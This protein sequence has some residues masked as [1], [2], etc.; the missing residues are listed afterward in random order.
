MRND[1]YSEG[2]WQESVLHNFTGSTDGSNPSTNVLFDNASE[3]CCTNV[4]LEQ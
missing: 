1:I 4:V 2:V 3:G